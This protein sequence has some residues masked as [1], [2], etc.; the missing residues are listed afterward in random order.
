M[1]ITKAIEKEVARLE[2]C[3]PL[4]EWSWNSHQWG[5][6]I[7]Y[8]SGTCT[9]H[10]HTTEYG[11]LSNEAEFKARIDHMKRSMENDFATIYTALT[12]LVTI[13]GKGMEVN[14][15]V[16][17][18]SGCGEAMGSISLTDPMLTS[19][20][21]RWNRLAHSA[22]DSEGSFIC[23]MCDELKT[24]D[25]FDYFWFAGRYCHECAEKNPDHKRQALAE[26][27]N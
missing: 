14:C 18:G 4:F 2:K 12:F 8:K 19:T 21:D 20:L 25:D 13:S 6:S 17:R 23:T 24:K 7:V 15:W 22:L 5:H 27:Y 16:R 10:N 1:D 3:F 9:M 11:R 26:N